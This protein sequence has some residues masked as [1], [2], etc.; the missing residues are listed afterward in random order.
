MFG[1]LFFTVVPGPPA[2]AMPGLLVQTSGSLAIPNEP[3]SLDG[4]CIVC[5]SPGM[6]DTLLGLETT[7]LGLGL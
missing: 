1:A 5:V 7:S 6:C 2:P 4:I 3:A